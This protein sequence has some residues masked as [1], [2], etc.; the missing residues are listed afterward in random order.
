MWVQI[1]GALFFVV[2]TI[3]EAS[4]LL[5]PSFGMPMGWIIYA[6]AAAAMVFEAWRT[7]RKMNEETKTS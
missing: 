3:G 2:I 1:V 5:R 4:G 6:L 7:R